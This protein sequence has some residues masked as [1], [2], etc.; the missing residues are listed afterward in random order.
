MG[1]AIGGLDWDNTYLGDNLKENE[2]GGVRGITPGGTTTEIT[3]GEG[4][5][6]RGNEIG[7]RGQ[8]G[9]VRGQVETGIPRGVMGGGGERGVAPDNNRIAGR[10]KKNGVMKNEGARE[11]II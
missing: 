11:K 5:M 6:K 3:L 9:V 7:T 10:E 8:G 4:E 1:V 2:G